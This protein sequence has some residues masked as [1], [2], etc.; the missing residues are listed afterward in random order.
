MPSSRKSAAAFAR[1]ACD[2]GRKIS[3]ES[4]RR[5]LRRS[6]QPDHPS[7]AHLADSHRPLHHQCG[8]RPD[9]HRR[10]GYATRFVSIHTWT[11]PRRV[12]PYNSDAWIWKNGE[13]LQVRELKAIFVTAGPTKHGS[14]AGR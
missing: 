7:S 1:L 13:L 9:A 11:D 4:R 5:K 3:G 8:Q 6:G 14:R 10:R 12:G 2:R